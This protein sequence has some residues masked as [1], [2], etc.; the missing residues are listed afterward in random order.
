MERGR[1]RPG[2]SLPGQRPF[3]PSSG[4]PPRDRPTDRAG[5]G[6]AAT[7]H[8]SVP[9]PPG[10][11]PAP[12]RPEAARREA[13]TGDSVS[14][15]IY[16]A[17]RPRRHGARSAPSDTRRRSAWAAATAC[18]RPPAADSRSA[19]RSRPADRRRPVVPYTYRRRQVQRGTDLRRGEQSACAGR[20]DRRRGQQ[21][22][23]AGRTDQRRGAERVS[24]G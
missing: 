9:V 17:S 8:R 21:N 11:R 16:T 23:S 4:P 22:A 2:G 18:C 12:A 5:C 14:T 13:M 20:T 15:P 6:A 7:G 19:R 3:Y 1:R 10:V 24:A